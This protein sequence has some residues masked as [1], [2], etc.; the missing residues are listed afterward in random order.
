[1]NRDEKRFAL[2]CVAIVVAFAG[3]CWLITSRPE[4]EPQGI[5]VAV[6][7]GRVVVEHCHSHA[8]T[9]DRLI[10][11]TYTIPPDQDAPVVGDWFA[12]DWPYV[13][14]DDVGECD[15]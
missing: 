4:G 14:S 7:D 6:A 11:I 13:G 10:A 5:V 15:L 3:V 2:L 9:S 12:H 8:K 1:M